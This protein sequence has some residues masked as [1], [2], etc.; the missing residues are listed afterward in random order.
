MAAQVERLLPEAVDAWQPPAGRRVVLVCAS[1]IRAAKAAAALAQRGI[2][3]LA[4]IA[5][6]QP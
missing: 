2:G 3:P 4:I 5:A 1:G 6:S